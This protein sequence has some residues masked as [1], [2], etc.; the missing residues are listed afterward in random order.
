M[1]PITWPVKSR[2]GTATQRNSASNSPSSKA[3]PARRT[4][5][6]SR[7]SAPT[8]MIDFGVCGLQ[9]GALEIALELLGAQRRQHDLA[10]RRAVRRPDDA[11]AVGQLEGARP[12]GA[13]DHHD[14]IAHADGEM[15]A[16]AGLARQVLQDRRRQADHLDVVERAGG[17]REQ[18]PPHPIALGVLELAH[19][20][21]RHHGLDQ[22]KGRAVVQP[23][24]LAQL[25]QA[26]AVAAARD[27]LQDGKGA[28]DRLHAAAAR[29]V[30][31]SSTCTGRSR[32]AMVLRASDG[33]P[34]AAARAGRGFFR[35]CSMSHQAISDFLNPVALHHECVGTTYSP[36]KRPAIRRP[37]CCP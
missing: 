1:A 7:R 11:D 22:V 2:T 9:F 33:A 17:E 21:E 26:D 12:A 19:V 4:S 16:L 32:T 37:V 27:L 34:V 28:P 8:S 25:G 29:L 14:G 23:D 35:S 31:S 13:G 5:S 10:E 20:A 15:P 6:I 24:P 36:R 30:A 3:M 18:R